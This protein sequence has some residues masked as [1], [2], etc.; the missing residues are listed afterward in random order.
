MNVRG[1]TALAVTLSAGL[2]PACGSAPSRDGGDPSLESAHMSRHSVEATELEAALV[3]GD[4]E[5]A[6]LPA[7]WLSGHEGMNG[8]GPE[9]DVFVTQM[10]E[11]AGGIFASTSLE[12]AAVEM[13][14]MGMACGACHLATGTELTFEWED[15]APS[16]ME[17]QPHM[18]R[19]AWAV[20]RL[21][22]GLSG[23]SD[24]AWKMG[25][26]VLSGDPLDRE[27]TTAEAGR[28]YRAEAWDQLVHS[29][30]AEAEDA[31]PAEKGEF[32][33]QVLSACNACHALV[34]SQS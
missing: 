30:A 27:H 28:R 22:E 12:S 34:R 31:G 8:L 16:S 33:S 25:A 2:L 19:H 21:W 3:D 14:R 5:R 29:L 20:D 11:A 6:K 4:L 9:T 18:A 7:A 13:G 17:L 10:R 26:R 15:Y 1:I 24:E 23:P 32:Y